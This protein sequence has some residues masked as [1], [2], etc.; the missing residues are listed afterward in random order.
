MKSKTV[1]LMNML[2]KNSFSHSLYFK[3]NR[4]SWFNP[5]IFITAVV[6]SLTRRCHYNCRKIPLFLWKGV[7]IP[8]EKWCYFY[9]KIFLSIPKTVLGFRPI[10]LTGSFSGRPV[11]SRGA[12][13]QKTKSINWPK[14]DHQTVFIIKILR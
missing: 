14:Q 2:M 13:R 12:S 8:I 11:H 5:A 3:S 7:V 6:I 4:D 1:F 10:S 9:R